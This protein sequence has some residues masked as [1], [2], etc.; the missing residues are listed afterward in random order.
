VEEQN[1]KT[2]HDGQTKLPK[3]KVV[4]FKV[5]ELDN[6]SADLDF[7]RGVYNRVASSCKPHIPR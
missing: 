2:L 1:S 5:K 6:Y 4:G 7:A 3:M